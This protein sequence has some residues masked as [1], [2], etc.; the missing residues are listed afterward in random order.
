MT[1]FFSRDTLKIVIVGDILDNFAFWI[2]LIVKEM[3]ERNPWWSRLLSPR[4]LLF[5]FLVTLSFLLPVF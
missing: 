4:D 3:G 2:S 5:P 1:E